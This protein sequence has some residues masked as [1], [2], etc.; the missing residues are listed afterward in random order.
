M[1][2][3][4]SKDAVACSLMHSTVSLRVPFEV[5]SSENFQLVA[6]SQTLI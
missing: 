6:A 1:L 2:R 5:K 4:K 3:T